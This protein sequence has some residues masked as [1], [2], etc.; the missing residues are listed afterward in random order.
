MNYFI[1]E[2]DLRA[3]LGTRVDLK[4]PA[5]L[6]DEPF[7]TWLEFSREEKIPDFLW[8]GQRDSPVF[9]V[10]DEMKSILEIYD[11]FLGATPVFLTDTAC[12]NQKVYWSIKLKEEACLVQNLYGK[13][14]E[15]ILCCEPDKDLY[16]FKARNERTWYP[17]VSLELAENLLRRHMYGICFYPIKGA[18]KRCSS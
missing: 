16:F 2:Q 17:V 3:V 12:R 7:V 11:S 5:F 6:G 8:G 13:K 9:C 18:G 4:N 1:M 10:S 15:Q 14:E